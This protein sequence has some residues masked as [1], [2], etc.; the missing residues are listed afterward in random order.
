MPHLSKVN[1]GIAAA[2]VVA[3]AAG[4][5]WMNRPAPRYKPD[6]GNLFPIN[7]NGKYGYMDRTGKTVITPQFDAALGFS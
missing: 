2:I 5:W 7:V 3:I 4:Y 6:N 1:I